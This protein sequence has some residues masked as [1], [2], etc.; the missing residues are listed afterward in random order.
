MACSGRVAGWHCDRMHGRRNW[1]RVELKIIGSLGER[2]KRAAIVIAVL[3]MCAWSFGQGNDKPATQNPP[4]GQAAG[5]A[6]AGQTAAGQ[7]ATTPPGKRP[8][9]VNSQEE[10]AAYKAAV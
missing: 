10:F 7:T 9:K 4:A 6:A 1:H 3:G 2:M 5:Q 8:P